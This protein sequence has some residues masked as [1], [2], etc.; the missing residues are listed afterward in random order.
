MFKY[1]TSIVLILCKRPRSC[2][3]SIVICSILVIKN[4]RNAIKLQMQCRPMGCK[5]FQWFLSFTYVQRHVCVT[6]ASV[7]LKRMSTC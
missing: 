6:Y 2:H 1:N 5:L 3:G 7:L 4:K